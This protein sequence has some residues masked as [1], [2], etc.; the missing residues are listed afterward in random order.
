MIMKKKK[1]AKKTEKKAEIKDDIKNVCMRC[2]KIF[3]SRKALKMHSSAHLRAL[4][5]LQMLEEG[6]IPDETKFGAGFK[7]KNKI[8]VS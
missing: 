8:I 1:A 2:G 6:L 5:E 7:G 3:Q 4:R